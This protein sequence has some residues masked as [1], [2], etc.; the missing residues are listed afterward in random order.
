M[1]LDA[2]LDILLASKGKTGCVVSFILNSLPDD[3]R[4]KLESLLS[5]EVVPA[6]RIAEVLV[7]H[8]F[9]VQD[10]SIARHRRRLRGAGCSCP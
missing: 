2:E 6:S 10:K 4:V 8:G 9:T 1:D 7:K 5:A 3:Q